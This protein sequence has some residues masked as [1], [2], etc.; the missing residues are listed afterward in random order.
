MEQSISVVL[1][2]HTAIDG[3]VNYKIISFCFDN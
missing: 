2:Q 1:K 3:P